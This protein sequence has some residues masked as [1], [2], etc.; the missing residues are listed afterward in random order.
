MI[1]DKITSI[2]HYWNLKF[3]GSS[4]GL[5]IDEFLYSVK[6]L[7]RETFN[8]DFSAVCRN[9]NTLLTGKAREWYWRCHKQVPSINWEH[10]CE[11]M[12]NQYKDM[13]SSF[14]LREEIRNRKQ[15]PGES[16]DTFFDALS[17]IADSD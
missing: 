9:M 17:M 7:T 4:T 12:K 2:I 6:T 3:D 15:K 10:F 14:D 13:K 1:A 16:Y 5:S 11:A 8:D